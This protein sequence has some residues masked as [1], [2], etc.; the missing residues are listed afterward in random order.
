MLML[1]TAGCSSSA[2]QPT[3]TLIPTATQIPPTL[4]PTANVEGTFPIGKFKNDKLNQEQTFLADGRTSAFGDITP[5]GGPV[6]GTYTVTGDQVTMKDDYCGDVLG[7]YIWIYDGKALSFKTINDECSI[8]ESL[9][10]L[11]KWLKEP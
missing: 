5:S 10:S 8:R 11:G 6:V 2:D 9:L 3:P 1:I 4:T 7:T